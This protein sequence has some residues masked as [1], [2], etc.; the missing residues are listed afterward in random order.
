MRLAGVILVA[1]GVSGCARLALG[2]P[3]ASPPMTDVPV[4]SAA[5][6]PTPTPA[7]TSSPGPEVV[8]TTEVCKDTIQELQP[9]TEEELGYFSRSDSSV[10]YEIENYGVSFEEG[11]RRVL[12]SSDVED[13][14]IDLQR[15][16]RELVDAIF[17]DRAQFRAVI[18]T[19][20]KKSVEKLCSLVADWPMEV[21]IQWGA[22]YTYQELHR[23]YRTISDW[24]FKHESGYA[25]GVRIFGV[26]RDDS[27]NSVVIVGPEEPSP[28]VLRQLS[29]L[30]GGVNVHW[31]LQAHPDGYNW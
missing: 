28:E 11:V 27:N 31:W 3:P 10:R 22:P 21:A 14:L 26:G 16:H 9:P 5:P 6:T 18:R 20:E 19:V 24:V 1:V 15:T 29:E 8:G 17:L 12:V 4:Q 2:S 30:G 7:P 13:L 25:F 23:A